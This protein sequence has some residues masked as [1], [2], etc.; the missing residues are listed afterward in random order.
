MG[1]VP[2]SAWPTQ[3][4]TGHWR[5]NELLS[6]GD[7]VLQKYSRARS[8][9]SSRSAWEGSSQC[10]KLLD[11]AKTPIRF[12]LWTPLA[13][14]TERH[15]LHS[16]WFVPNFNWRWHKKLAKPPHRFVPLTEPL[17]NLPDDI[18]HPPPVEAPKVLFS[19]LPAFLVRS[20]QLEVSDE[21]RASLTSTFTFS[22][23]GLICLRRFF[24]HCQMDW[25]W[26]RKNFLS[27]CLT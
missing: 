8:H 14:S 12:R 3:K 23:S 13:A 15:Q 10:P 27:K 24:P 18:I 17:P 22:M 1:F 9:V 7:E 19:F 26:L 4:S 20:A 5:V 2:S 21:L 6:T 16:C 11:K 25:G